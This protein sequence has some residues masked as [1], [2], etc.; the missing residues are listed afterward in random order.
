MARALAMQPKLLLL[1]EIAGGLTEYE[2]GELVKTIKEIH[3]RGTTIVW[4]EHI[5][6]ALVSVASRLI[7]MDFGQVLAQGDPRDVM[8]DP[9]VRE[10]YMGI[11]A[12]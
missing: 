8:A 6:H 12:S 4:I 10:V 3:G 1:D 7:V 9:R 2:C 11:P 5:V